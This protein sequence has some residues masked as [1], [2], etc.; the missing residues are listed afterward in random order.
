M[1]V[2]SRKFAASDGLLIICDSNSQVTRPR[3]LNVGWR[4]LRRFGVLEA[5]QVRRGSAEEYVRMLP[6]CRAAPVGWDQSF[7]P[8]DG[9]LKLQLFRAADGS[10]V[11]APSPDPRGRGDD[12]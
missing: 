3:C 6:R 7:S 9:A 11:Q 10:G 4:L 2:W 8:A 1:G 12:G 5:V